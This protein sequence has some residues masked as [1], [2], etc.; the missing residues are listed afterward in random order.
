M[1]TLL[2]SPC[3]ERPRLVV[4]LPDLISPD[5]NVLIA[6]GRG[7][8]PPA[9]RSNAVVPVPCPPLLAR[10]SV[11]GLRFLGGG[12]GRRGLRDSVK[13]REIS[14][15]VLDLEHAE[16]CPDP[17][18][19][20]LRLQVRR[21]GKGW[22]DPRRPAG[23]NIAAA[24]PVLAPS[25]LLVLRGQHGKAPCA[26]DA[27]RGRFAGGLDIS[28]L[29]RICS[30]MSTVGSGKVAVAAPNLAEGNSLLDVLGDVLP[31]RR[32]KVAAEPDGVE[33]R[34]GIHAAF[35]SLGSGVPLTVISC[36][37]PPTRRFPCRAAQSV[38][39]AGS[40][41]IG[42]STCPFLPLLPSLSPDFSPLLLISRFILAC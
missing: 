13:P 36:L 28:M 41:V 4:L 3:P 38:E 16:R 9:S 32:P 23:S 1:L 33:L 15:L 39:P 11:V 25:V 20:Q 14:A 6:R 7:H 19:G 37:E 31:P 42:G 12:Q 26:G 17:P 5:T 30:R 8:P 22:R 21:R 35:P 2:K 27:P 40:P 24:L 18:H 34:E 29:G 10:T